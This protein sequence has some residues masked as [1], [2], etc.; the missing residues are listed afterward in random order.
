MA[1]FHFHRCL[2]ML[3]LMRR[4]MFIFG[5]YDDYVGHINICRDMCRYLF[6]QAALLYSIFIT[7]IW[8]VD[9]KPLDRL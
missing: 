8:F 6:V 5:G 9:L 4:R 7:H 1:A 2:H 3:V